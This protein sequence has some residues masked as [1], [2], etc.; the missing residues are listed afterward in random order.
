[1]TIIFCNKIFIC[2]IL[3]IGIKANSKIPESDLKRVRVCIKLQQKKYEE[4]EKLVN[5]FLENKS[6]ILNHTKNQ[7]LLL[8]MAFCYNKI[9]EELSNII[10]R[11]PIQKLNIDEL[12]IREIY[13]FENYN[14]DNQ[15]MN[16]KIYD[17][18]LPAFEVVY[19]EIANIEE[20]KE[21]GKYHLSFVDTY[22]FKFFIFYT[23]INSIIVFYIR[24]KNSSK[25]INKTENFEEE[26]EKNN[27][28]EEEINREQTDNNEDDKN[29][30]RKLKKKN[31]L[32]KVKR[33]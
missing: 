1:M 32:G 5:S 6:K 30:H 8:A 31:R 10:A 24:I 9:S 20:K 25:Y 17:S 7:V 2:F 16:K 26:E 21:K 33:N 13:D 19:K 23:I 15:E 28:E 4:N 11:S 29:D 18:F 27:D 3:I 14:Y 22:L 12:N